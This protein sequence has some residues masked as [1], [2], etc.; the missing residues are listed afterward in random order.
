MPGQMFTMCCAKLK[1]FNITV[2]SIAL[3]FSFLNNINLLSWAL[4]NYDLL[5]WIQHDPN[6][7]SK[8]VLIPLPTFI[9]LPTFVEHAF[10]FGNL[11]H[12]SYSTPSNFQGETLIIFLYSPGSHTCAI[13]SQQQCSRYLPETFQV[14]VVPRISAS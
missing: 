4:E 14:G 12:I 9:S 10:G 13:T 3:C 2:P 8:N 11:L 5:T 7:H 1:A 6:L